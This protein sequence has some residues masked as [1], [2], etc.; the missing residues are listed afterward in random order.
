MLT[1][2]TWAIQV[3]TQTS[4]SDVLEFEPC[5]IQGA[6]NFLIV[7]VVDSRPIEA[8]GG[9]PRSL[10]PRSVGVNGCRK[11]KVLRF[12]SRKTKKRICVGKNKNAKQ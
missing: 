12:V 8:V 11:L 3:R 2:G 9:D 6:H 5:F 10:S 7:E 4:V 1:F